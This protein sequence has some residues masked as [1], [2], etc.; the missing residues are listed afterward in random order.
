[1]VKGKKIINDVKQFFAIDENENDILIKEVI[2]ETKGNYYCPICGSEMIACALEE[3]KQSAHFRHKSKLECTEDKVHWWYKNKYFIKDNKFKV[4]INGILKTYIVDDIDIEKRYGT[5]IGVYIPDVVIHTSIGEDIFFE[6][7]NTNRK[8]LG[9]YFDIWNELGNT[10]IELDLNIL[11][12]RSESEKVFTPLFYNGM[13]FT[14]KLNVNL[15]RHLTS[16]KIEDPYR[17]KYLNWFWRDCCRYVNDE[18]CIDDLV[19]VIDS[20]N[21]VDLLIAPKVIKGMSCNSILDDY[22][23]YKYN[24]YVELILNEIKYEFSVSEEKLIPFIKDELDLKY[25]RKYSD[26]N[27]VRFLN[28]IIIKINENYKYVEKGFNIFGEKCNKELIEM[29]SSIIIKN[30]RRILDKIKEPT[31]LIINNQK[32]KYSQYF[33]SYMKN[34]LLSEIGISFS[35]SRVSDYGNIRLCDELELSD[36]YIFENIYDLSSSY[37]GVGRKEY[38]INKTIEY[39]KDRISNAYMYFS[40]FKNKNNNSTKFYL[41]IVKNKNNEIIYFYKEIEKTFYKNQVVQLPYR[42]EYSHRTRNF[43]YTCGYFKC[44][45]KIKNDYELNILKRYVYLKFKEKY[46]A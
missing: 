40:S 14:E 6:F 30:K 9:D 43:I 4:L 8:V 37:K 33:D 10:V 18:T 45:Y 16:K 7:K 29:A 35:E 15:E 23:N 46:S 22:T 28:T 3:N 36:K 32:E 26:F 44:K 2:K 24:K 25:S 20:L 13:V 38:I 27:S 1:M 5:T 19:Q 11:Q 39:V 42:I 21:K 34:R 12:L 41:D 17:I 31:K